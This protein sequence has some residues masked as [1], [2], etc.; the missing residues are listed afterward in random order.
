MDELKR[1][2]RVVVLA[3]SSK[4]LEIDEAAKRAGRID[5]DIEIPVPSELDRHEIL[6]HL[7]QLNQVT[8]RS[9]T[10]SNTLDFSD[11][12]TKV[13]ISEEAVRTLAR[14]GHGMVGSD[15]LQVVKECFYLTVMKKQH[16]LKT[17]ISLIPSNLFL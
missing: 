1:E 5:L 9:D 16:I 12:D 17:F 6:T 13:I 2:D 10:S 11:I 15:L 8:I 4:P 3:I 14:N 7:F